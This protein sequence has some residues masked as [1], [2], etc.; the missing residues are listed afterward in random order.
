MISCDWGFLLRRG[1]AS[2]IGGAAFN[3]MHVRLLQFA[4][5]VIAKVDREHPAD[6]VLRAELKAARLPR[7][8]AGAVSR[9]VFAFERW[10][11]W[12]D[13]TRAL[14]MQVAA[15]VELAE[16]F[17]R[18]P[19]SFPDAELLERAVPAWTR[20]HVAV[21][22]AWVR[23]LQREP[24]LW[25][26]ARRGEGA[27]VV[28]GLAGAAA[29]PWADSVCFAGEE[30]LFRTAAFQ[31]G[32]F[33]LQDI[34]SQAV[35]K[36][37]DPQPGET[38]WDA[39]AGEGGKT[40]HLSSLMENRGLIWASD[41]VEWRLQRLKLR[42]GRAGVFNYRSALWEG[43]ERLPTKTLFD[44]VLVD[45]PCSGSG[46]W[47]RNPHAR[48]TVTPQ[49]VAELAAVQERL[50]ANAAR[51]VKPGGRLVYAVCTL[52]GAETTG[53]AAAFE[54]AHPGFRAVGLRDPFRPAE[55][56]R[57]Q[58]WLWPQVTGGNGMFVAVWERRA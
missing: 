22:P 6:A 13:G 49:D 1:G 32:A 18:E 29:G 37:C 23:A 31:A 9:A 34:A 30:D 51:G 44:G 50:L 52:T 40:L 7:R 54:R 53:V 14:A 57:V 36:L 8:D 27:G 45:G 28:A 58:L 11:R 24:V 42:A 46:T 35:G 2:G 21:S 33:E 39:C 38:W 17:A 3:F 41:R 12:L 19:E 16:R 48:W 20:E 25:L 47:G 26:R 10:H 4:A 15:A 56:A 5:T 43:G 55:T